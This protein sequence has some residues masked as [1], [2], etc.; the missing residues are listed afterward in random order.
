MIKTMQFICPTG[1]YGAERWVLMLARALDERVVRSDLV[2][3][4]ERG[5]PELELV[6]RY[7][8]HV[9]EISTSGRFDVRAVSTLRALLRERGTDVL[10][11]HGYKSDLIG[12]VAA[13]L[14]GT[15]CIST[16]HGF[17][18][19]RHMSRLRKL[20]HH[21]GGRSLRWFDH[22]VPLSPELVDEVLA[23]GVPPERVS[24]VEN[25]V[26]L[27]D[28]PDGDAASEAVPVLSEDFRE[29]RI[30]AFAGQLIPRKRVDRIIDTFHSLWVDDPSL[31][32]LILG[33]GPDRAS[34]EQRVDDA[35]CADAVRFLGFREDRLHLLR[36]A[37]LFVMASSQEG[38]PRVMM[39][40]MSLALPIVAYDIA[41]V[42]QL[43]EHDVDGL[44]APG[45]N[46]EFY[47]HCWRRVLDEPH[48]A[49][50]LGSAALT[51]VHARY[52]QDRLAREY[53]EIFERVAGTT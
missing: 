51:K 3:V 43:I 15:P 44:L 33:D 49:E 31:G 27:T 23:F 37:S 6:A 16:P 1:F 17:G 12:L 4:R 46:E 2:V 29:R 47:R 39:E 13:R 32:L 42:D 41:G 9:T 25:A 11:T 21:A 14:A 8:G 10:H 36:D 35:G 5:M 7:P 48:T 18:E 20:Y 53:T 26:D 34:L 50:R 28:V 24:L 52:S 40:A 19:T 38:V 22:V 30:I 45:G